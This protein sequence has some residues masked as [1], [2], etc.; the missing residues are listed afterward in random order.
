MMPTRTTTIEDK[1]KEVLRQ[2][3]APAAVAFLAENQV[4]VE[5]LRA[6]L[7]ARLK[8]LAQT[9]I[10]VEKR[11]IV[12]IY[13]PENPTY[14]EGSWRIETQ[15]ESPE[16]C[17]PSAWTEPRTGFSRNSL[18]DSMHRSTPVNSM[19]DKVTGNTARRGKR[20]G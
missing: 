16:P 3:D 11:H 12:G 15:P 4:E 10:P 18:W 5:A 13:P 7:R 17:P 8:N 9:V 14:V 1:A 2:Q 6:V 20:G 19:A